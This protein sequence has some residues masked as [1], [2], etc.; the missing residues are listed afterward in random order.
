MQNPQQSPMNK[1]NKVIWIGMSPRFIGL[2]ITVLSGIVEERPRIEIANPL[3]GIARVEHQMNMPGIGESCMTNGLPSSDTIADMDH[4]FLSVAVSDVNTS[5]ERP[6]VLNH[7]KLD[8]A[9]TLGLQLRIL[10]S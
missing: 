4:C 7:F 1:A 10:R 6:N 9:V 5:L 3:R 8:D 2:A